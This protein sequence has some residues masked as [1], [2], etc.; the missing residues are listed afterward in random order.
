LS[1]KEISALS[2]LFKVVELIKQPI[3]KIV[4]IIEDASKKGHSVVTNSERLFTKEKA[5]VLI[6]GQSFSRESNEESVY[7]CLKELLHAISFFFNLICKNYFIK[8]KVRN[9]LNRLVMF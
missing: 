4:E 5:Q 7:T 1:V 8:Y 9:L 6:Q 3:K 2:Q